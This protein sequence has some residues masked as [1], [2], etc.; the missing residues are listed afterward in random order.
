MHVARRTPHTRPLHDD[1]GSLPTPPAAIAG[2]TTVGWA[3]DCARNR[4]SYYPDTVREDSEGW[5][6]TVAL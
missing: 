1:E 2:N 6:V 4:P 5:T 3:S